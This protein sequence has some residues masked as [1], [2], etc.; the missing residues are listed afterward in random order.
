MD[1][2]DE[3]IT[4]ECLG[5][6][7]IQRPGVLSYQGSEVNTYTQEVT[8]FQLVSYKG[9]LVQRS[10]HVPKKWQVFNSYPKGGLEIKGHIQ[11][12]MFYNNTSAV[13]LLLP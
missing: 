11:E 10:I 2:A 4:S 8:S 6:I 12:E 3:L 5:Q 1:E 13:H 7:D 9:G